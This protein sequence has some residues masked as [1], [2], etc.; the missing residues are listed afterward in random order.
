MFHDPRPAERSPSLADLRSGVSENVIV[1]DGLL[2]HAAAALIGQLKKRL[3]F[4]FSVTMI[5]DVYVEWEQSQDRK[6]DFKA[7]IKTWQIKEV[8]AHEAEE[9]SKLIDAF[10][11]SFGCSLAQFVEIAFSADKKGRTGP[12]PSPHTKTDRSA[13]RFKALG[14]PKLTPSVVTKYAGLLKRY[15]PDLLPLEERPSGK[16]VPFQPKK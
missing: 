10:E 6:W 7:G 14:Y 16:V 12:V 11:T 15:R 2:L 13:R 9:A 3:A 5:S 4:C 8:A 1:S